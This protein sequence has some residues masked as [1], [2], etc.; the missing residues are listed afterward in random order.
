LLVVGTANDARP[1]S[2]R[3]YPSTVQRLFAVA[4]AVLAFAGL[5]AGCSDSGSSEASDGCSNAW[6]RY[7]R[8]TDS[9]L[10]PSDLAAVERR[11]LAACARS[12]WLTHLADLDRRRKASGE[13]ATEQELKAYLEDLCR[14]N[15]QTRACRA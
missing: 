8:A 10:N 12:Q 14:T 1:P 3:A 7:E 11:T 9:D 15:M 2:A 6:T 4:V 5:P 13:A